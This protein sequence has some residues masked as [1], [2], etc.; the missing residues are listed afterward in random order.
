MTS[1]RKNRKAKRSLKKVA[2]ATSDLLLR[3]KTYSG[4][5]AHELV[6]I[7]FKAD[8]DFFKRQLG[9]SISF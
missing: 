8:S 5:F 9:P 2:D 3:L 1:L 7:C 4:G 6:V